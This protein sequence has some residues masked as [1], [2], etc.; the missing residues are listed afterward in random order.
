[1]SDKKRAIHFFHT[2]PNN[3]NCA[4]SIIKTY[5]NIININDEEIESQYRCKGGGRAEGGFCGAVLS[6]YHILGKD[7]GDVIKSTIEERLGGCTCRKL[8][9]ELKIPCKQIVEMVDDLIES[10]I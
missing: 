9:G 8:K 7:K 10:E 5:Q 4:Q 3:Y 6:A 1:M 2:A